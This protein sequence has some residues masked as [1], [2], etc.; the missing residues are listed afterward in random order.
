MSIRF[1]AIIAYLGGKEWARPRRQGGSGLPVEG[2][3]L[4]FVKPSAFYSYD[5]RTP[6]VYESEHDYLA[7]LGLLDPRFDD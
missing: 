1:F 3:L 5:F 4:S 7:R 2:R 6:P